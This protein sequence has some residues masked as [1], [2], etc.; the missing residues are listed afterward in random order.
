MPINVTEAVTNFVKN[1]PKATE[2]QKKGAST[3]AAFFSS[4]DGDNLNASAILNS[5]VLNGGTNR[6]DINAALSEINPNVAQQSVA[7][8]Q[9]NKK[10]SDNQGPEKA[11]K[12]FF[13]KGVNRAILDLPDSPIGAPTIKVNDKVP[14]LLQ[15]EVKALMCQIGFIESEWTTGFSTSPRLGRYGVHSKTLTYYGYKDNSGNWT[16]KDGINSEIDFL[17][18]SN[19]QDRLMEKFIQDQYKALIQNKGIRDYDSKETVAGMI[20]VAYQF[21]D[22]NPSLSSLKSVTGFADGQNLGD[23]GAV[24][25]GANSLTS[26][27]ENTIQGGIAGLATSGTVAESDSVLTSTASTLGSQL[28][29][30]GV[31]SS[32]ESTL[33]SVK[34]GLEANDPAA[35]K[36]SLT[37]SGFID[38]LKSTGQSIKNDMKPVGDKVAGMSDAIKAK[39]K[40]QSA[41]TSAGV[42]NYKQMIA[43]KVNV[44]KLKSSASSIATAIPAE[45]AKQWRYNGTE[46]DSRGQNGTFYFNAGKYAIQGLA[47]DIPTTE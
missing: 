46:T 36:A 43:Q 2:E 41:A 35:V 7:P 15:T 21:Q 22:A 44:D 37:S 20:A 12:E 5:N 23:I 11:D 29:S 4:L 33:T 39:L 14:I 26:N 18:D 13:S 30:S 6:A 17:Y 38:K 40:E 27:L 8:A 24:V 42:E 16:G 47:A 19:V 3:A 10:V 45:K 31:G 28:D 1:N 25:S 9:H 34:P 32:L